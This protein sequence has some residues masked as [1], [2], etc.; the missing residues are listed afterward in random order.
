MKPKWNCYSVLPLP[1][2][3]WSPSWCQVLSCFPPGLGHPLAQRLLHLRAAW[4][5]SLS[6]HSHS[7][8]SRWSV[9]LGFPS[10]LRRFPVSPH[11]CPWASLPSCPGHHWS[12]WHPIPR[13]YKSFISPFFTFLRVSLPSPMVGIPKSKWL[14]GPPSLPCDQRVV[15]FRPLPE[16]IFE[17]GPHGPPLGGVGGGWAKVYIGVVARAS[18]ACSE[19]PCLLWR[20]HSKWVTPKPVLGTPPPPHS[21][22]VAPRGR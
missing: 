20:L 15:Q 22:S 18:L 1:G 7:G 4:G 3:W 5:P 21:V 14:L 19:P 17:E 13:A 8:A 10:A 12:L 16:G 6:C 2:D 11:S 9:C